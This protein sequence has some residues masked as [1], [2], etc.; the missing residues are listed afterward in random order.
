MNKRFT[1]LAAGVAAALFDFTQ[2]DMDAE[3]AKGKA[4]GE[5][6]AAAAAGVVDAAPSF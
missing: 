6:L 3:F 4:E 2:E 5:A 1:T